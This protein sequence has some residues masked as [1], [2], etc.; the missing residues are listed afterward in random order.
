VDFHDVKGDLESI[1]AP[2]KPEFARHAHPSLH[3]GRCAQVRIDGR[4]VGVIGELHPALQQALEL[5]SA[6][7]LFE[8]DLA[9]LRERTIPVYSELS[10][11]PAVMRDI[12]LIVP[13]ELPAAE[14]E[15]AIWRAVREEP[16][17]AIIQQVF[18]FDEYR[19]KGLENKEKSLA[20]RLR[21]QDTGRTLGDAD[22]QRA[23]Q[24]VVERLEQAVGARLRA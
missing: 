6:P 7:V 1:Y 20:F 13:V 15:G 8:V 11:F 10:K 16:E 14:V 9:D 12:A 4:P 24:I 2:M 5:P 22:T 21:M 19:G 23:V 3:P 18:L 17:A